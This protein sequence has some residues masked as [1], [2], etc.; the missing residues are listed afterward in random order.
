MPTSQN[1]DAERAQHTKESTSGVH[2]PVVGIARSTQEGERG[3]D[4]LNCFRQPH[5][6]RCNDHRTP[7]A[8][9]KEQGQREQDCDVRQG[10]EALEGNGE[11]DCAPG[12]ATGAAS[13]CRQLV[14][15]AGV[16]VSTSAPTRL[17]V[18]STKG[19]T[20]AWRWWS[21][22]PTAATTTIPAQ[23]ATLTTGACST[24]NVEIMVG[25]SPGN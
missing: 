4:E 9:D 16:S 22:H 13:W 24:R 17:I 21:H 11:L 5:N 20:R 12:T 25:P 15:P 7:G 8:Q 23:K 18:A 6:S 3:L 2:K 14:S 10:V 1:E 19:A